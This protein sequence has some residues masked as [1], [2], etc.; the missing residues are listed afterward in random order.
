M[1]HRFRARPAFTLIELLVVVA[2]IAILMALLLPA[3]QKV[4]E[5]ANKMKCGNN[6]KQLGIAAH[7][8]AHDH[9][10]LPPGYLGP[11]PNA[12]NPP[13]PWAYPA[14]NGPN[15]MTGAITFLLPYVEQEPLYRLFYD[16]PPAARLFDIDRR[17]NAWW[18]TTPGFNLSRTKIPMFLCP[19]D[20]AETY[21]AGVFVH[22]HTWNDPT[23][24]WLGGWF[25]AGASGGNPAAGNYLG[26]A[27]A[28][29]LTGSTAWNRWV[30]AFY[31]RSRVE[32]GQITAADGTSMTALFG[33][34][35]GDVGPTIQRRS[36]SWMAGCLP[37]AWGLPGSTT[38]SS[39]FHFS[40]RHVSGVQFCF[41]DGSVRT[42][43][44]GITAND[45]YRPLTGTKDSVPVL[46][47]QEWE[48]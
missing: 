12:P 27:G 41:A 33:E 2:I 38:E 28:G 13:A 23:F 32:I 9:K 46:K 42:L 8:F 20:N 16:I 18:S 1:S 34:G 47:L 26:V 19:S 29:G 22:F 6:L 17:G 31:S 45:V 43:K 30:G 11:D 7:A 36:W 4:R 14:P 5:A 37:T 39:W 44:R 3:V 15:Q 48:F 21:S 10:R 40:S 25:F 24:L 35:M